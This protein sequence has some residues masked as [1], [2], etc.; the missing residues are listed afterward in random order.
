M[1]GLCMLCGMSS[2]FSPGEMFRIVPFHLFKISIVLSC[3]TSSMKNSMISQVH[4]TLSF[5]FLSHIIKNAF[6]QT[7]VHVGVHT[8]RPST[9]FVICLGLHSLTVTLKAGH[10]TY[11]APHPHYARLIVGDAP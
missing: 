7:C 4:N 9:T 3:S 8:H 10:T 2:S 6:M 11:L 1:P 5:Q